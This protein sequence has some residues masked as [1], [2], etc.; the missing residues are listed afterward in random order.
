MKI[1][2]FNKKRRPLGNLQLCWKICSFVRQFWELQKNF[3]ASLEN[4]EKGRQFGA[5]SENLELR[6]VKSFIRKTR[7]LH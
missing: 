5:M 6:Q 2:S 3:R 4:F 1:W 7:N